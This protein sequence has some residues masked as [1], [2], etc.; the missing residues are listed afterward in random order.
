MRMNPVPPAVAA[1]PSRPAP[2]ADTSRPRATLVVYYSRRGHTRQVARLIAE[3]CGADIEEIVDG[4][5]R[6]GTLGYLRSLA[7]ALLRLKV[8]IQPSRCAPREYDTVI[9]GTPVWAWQMAS[10][11]RAYLSRHRGRF[12]RVALFCCHRGWGPGTVLQDAAGLCARPAMATLAL[13]DREVAQGRHRPSLS[14]FLRA[15]RSARQPRR[16]EGWRQAA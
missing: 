5:D 4:V 9:I 7:E 13:S 12:R 11:V 15:I 6:R 1:D 16:G 14:R 2:A 8:P 3:Q 10:P